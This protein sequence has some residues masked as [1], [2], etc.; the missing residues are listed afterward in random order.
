VQPRPTAVE[1]LACVAELLERDIVPTL[2]G[3]VQHQARVAANLV[4]IVERELRL[5]SAAQ[6]AELAAVRQ[7]LSSAGVTD[8]AT[9]LVDARAQL[10]V[11]LRAGLADDP[12]AAAQVWEVLMDV[13]R[14][15]LA[16]AKPGHDSWG[17]T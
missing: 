8:V 16:I 7:L 3:P 11:A 5:T 14:D 13:A 12:A 10:A 17:G 4:A 15:D 9:D 6:E 1:L 2:A